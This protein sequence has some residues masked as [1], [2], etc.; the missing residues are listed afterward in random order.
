MLFIL[1]LNLEAGRSRRDFVGNFARVAKFATLP[2]F[3]PA[4]SSKLAIP[5]PATFHCPLSIRFLS[6]I[7]PNLS[8]SIKIFHC[9]NPSLPLHSINTPPPLRDSISSLPDLS[10]VKP[11]P[12]GNTTTP[13]LKPSSIQAATMTKTH[14]GQ[15]SS[16]QHHARP[17]SPC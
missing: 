17:P 2:V 10:P 4:S 12:C 6:S 8:H 13:L 14:G 5:K 7:F 16:S 15:K 1:C 3:L 11:L 9:P